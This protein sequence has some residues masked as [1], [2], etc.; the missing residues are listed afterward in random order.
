M[1]SIQTQNSITMKPIDQRER[2]RGRN[3]ILTRR[4]KNRER[5][6]RYRA[7]KRLEA[8]LKNSSIIK[9][10]TSP[11]VEVQFNETVSN[12]TPRVHCKRNWKKDARRAHVSKNPEVTANAYAVPTLMSTSVSQTVFMSGTTAEPKFESE[13]YSEVSVDQNNCEMN[14]P[15]LGRRDW[16]ADARKKKN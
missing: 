10:S 12:Y 1:N 3:D 2:T 4:L 5:Q 8:E 13:T 16:K 9:P 7:R 11:D 6:R 15:K 14:R